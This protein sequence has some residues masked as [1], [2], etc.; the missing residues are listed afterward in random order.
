MRELANA[1][2]FTAWLLDHA[3]ATQRITHVAMAAKIEAS[4]HL[5]WR[6][7]AE[8]DASPNSGTMRMG[9]TPDRPAVLDRSRAA[10]KFDGVRLAEDL[11]V[12]LRRHWK[13]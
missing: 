8:Q 10:L 7:Q 11:M 9:G 5:G 6:T 12:P 1:I 13:A 4:D 3:D 2:A